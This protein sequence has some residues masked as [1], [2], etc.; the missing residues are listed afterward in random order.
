MGG[1]E[2]VARPFVLLLSVM[3]VFSITI[4]SITAQMNTS[5][6]SVNDSS[7][8]NPLD[9]RNILGDWSYTLIDP[10]GGIHISTANVTS[11]MHDPRDSHIIFTDADHNDDKKYLQIIRNNENFDRNSSN[12]WERY[13]DFISVQRHRDPYYG[14]DW[15]GASISYDQIVA[16]YEWK[17]NTSKIS[18][19]LSGSQAND[20]LFVVLSHNDT[21]E[22]W[23]NN[24][25]LYYGWSVLRAG[26]IDFWG[27]IGMVLTAQ[28]PGLEP[29]VQL[30]IDAIWIISLIFIGFTMAT[31]IS[32]LGGGG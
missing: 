12:M 3:A 17:T 27:V 7:N 32:P 5:A 4:M 6:S 2:K 16:N 8:P 15:G 10:E 21:T 22:I 1:G 11:H 19:R 23:N 14:D 31:R 25:T 29:H 26:S 28:V 20:T 24:Y 9:L 18:F 30:L 13:K